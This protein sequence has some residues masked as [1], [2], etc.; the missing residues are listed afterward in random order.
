MALL[1]EF[2]L[3]GAARPF[4]ILTARTKQT[5][6][7]D[8]RSAHLHVREPVASILLFQH[9]ATFPNDDDDHDSTA[10]ALELRWAAQR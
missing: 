5:T 1:L 4:H 10:V 6:Q 3:A 7:H 9:C 2:N 8:L